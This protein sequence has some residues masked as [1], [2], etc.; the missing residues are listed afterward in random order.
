MKNHKKTLIVFKGHVNE[1]TSFFYIKVTHTQL[2]KKQ[3]P[4]QRFKFTNLKSHK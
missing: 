3:H 2:S 1:W 4:V